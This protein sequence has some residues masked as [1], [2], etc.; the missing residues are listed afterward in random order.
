M[1][2]EKFGIDKLMFA[3]KILKRD[4]KEVLEKWFEI[5]H[6]SEVANKVGK[7]TVWTKQDDA[8]LIHLA[9]EFGTETKNWSSVS[10]HMQDKTLRQCRERWKCIKQK[11]KK[12]WETDEEERIIALVSKYGP[13]WNS[14]EQFFS[15]RSQ[16]AIKTHYYIISKLPKYAK[17]ANMKEEL[18]A[19]SGLAAKALSEHRRE[20]KNIKDC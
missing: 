14:F 1:V 5:M 20:K 16:H 17:V 10:K 13:K 3:A 2:C 6:G 8:K 11:L 7:R 4:G 12:R 15:N 19:F 18:D 9:S